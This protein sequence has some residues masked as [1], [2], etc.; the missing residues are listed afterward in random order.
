MALSTTRDM[1]EHAEQALRRGEW[2]M[3]ELY[4]KRGNQLVRADRLK[5][6]SD[7]FLGTKYAAEDLVESLNKSLTPVIKALS[8]AIGG[9]FKSF[10]EE[11]PPSQKD[12]TLA[13]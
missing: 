7:I 5:V 2:R 11:P 3:A 10:S 6:T 12:F 8:E 4:L 1:I 13:N 9:I